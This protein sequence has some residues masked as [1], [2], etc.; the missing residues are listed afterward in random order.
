MEFTGAS[1]S[2]AVRYLPQHGSTELAIQAFLD[3]LSKKTPGAAPGAA[4]VE[5]V[6]NQFAGGSSGDLAIDGVI[7]YVEALGF[8]PEDVEALVVAQ[9]VAL[10]TAGVIERAAFVDA[11][12]EAG[13][14]SLVDMAAHVRA[15]TAA[16]ATDADAFTALY[17]FAF[18]FAVDPPAR[19]MAADVACAYWQ[20][21][22]GPVF[23]EETAAWTRFVEETWRAPVNHDVWT[24]TLAFFRQ[25]HADPALGF[26]DPAA[27]WP[28][29]IDEFVETRSG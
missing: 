26:Y 28:T 13:A 4:A 2:L 17:E 6:F 8:Q 10:P 22:A 27:A 11:W 21:L 1:R 16:L 25:W 14:A 24:M 5:A 9:V 20:L 7:A 29:I 19:A 23:A 3:R 15:L 18:A 12:T